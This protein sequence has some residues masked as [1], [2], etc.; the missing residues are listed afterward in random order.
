MLIQPAQTSARL[1]AWIL[2]RN[3]RRINP[4][5]TAD[6]R[7]FPYRW[8]RSQPIHSLSVPRER[9]PAHADDGRRLRMKEFWKRLCQEDA[10]QDLTEYALLLVLMS[11][12]SIV[13]MRGI[14]STVNNIFTGA[15][16]NM[17]TAGS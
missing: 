6:D 13:A 1:S 16:T 3:G 11:L 14:G 12:L 8:E 7:W 4:S 5:A 17:G 10:G 15:S 2:L 9:T